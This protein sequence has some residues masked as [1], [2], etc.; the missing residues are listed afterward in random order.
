MN[1]GRTAF[2]AAALLAAL[3]VSGAKLDIGFG[4]QIRNYV[5]DDRRAH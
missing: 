4:S 1:A 3:P 2:A 5:L